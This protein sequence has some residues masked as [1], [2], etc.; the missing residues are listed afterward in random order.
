MIELRSRD[1]TLGLAPEIGGSVAYFRKG[2][3][4]VMRPLSAADRDRSEVLGAA[5]FP[6]IPYANRIADSQFTFEERT[7]T[8]E[9]NEPPS[10]FNVHGTAWR[11]PWSGQRSADNNPDRA[12][13]LGVLILKPGESARGSMSF[14]PFST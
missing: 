1:L 7:C 3:T 9:P 8:F 2:G 5:I 10:R 13:Y 4:D 12:E 6:M 14:Q 11:L